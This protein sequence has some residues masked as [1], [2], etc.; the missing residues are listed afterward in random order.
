MLIHKAQDC[1][2]LV[3]IFIRSN[4]LPTP[5]RGTKRISRVIYTDNFPKARLGGEGEINVF[6]DFP[7]IF[8]WLA[9]LS[10]S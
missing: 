2:I 9:D 7:W 1:I 4:S 5:R 8:S 10:L 3:L 6:N